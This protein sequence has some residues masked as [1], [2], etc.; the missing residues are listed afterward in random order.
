V[1]LS[2][3]ISSGEYGVNTAQ[4]KQLDIEETQA[5]HGKFNWYA[6]HTD[7]PQA[8]ESRMDRISV[9]K[10]RL[11]LLT[12]GLNVCIDNTAGR[13]TVRA[14]TSYQFKIKGTYWKP[15]TVQQLSLT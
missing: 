6:H 2:V 12:A 9:A 5:A 1:F 13:W 15:G 11:N 4:L 3:L 14:T 7:T 10:N 8:N